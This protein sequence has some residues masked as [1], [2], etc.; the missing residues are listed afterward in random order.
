MINVHLYGEDQQH[1]FWLIMLIVTSFSVMGS[2]LIIASYT[3]FPQI[4][5]ANSRI[6]VSLRYIFFMYFF[7]G[8]NIIIYFWCKFILKNVLLLS[9]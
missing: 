7:L 2:I 3:L 1:L 8:G 9:I 4:R 6:I 5:N